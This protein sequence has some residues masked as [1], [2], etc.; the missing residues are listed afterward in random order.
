[1]FTALGFITSTAEGRFTC[2]FL[3][4]DL[5]Q[6]FSGSFTARVQ[7]FT[8]N[9][10]SINYTSPDQLKS[11]QSFHGFVGPNNIELSLVDGAVIDGVLDETLSPRHT[12]SGSG[13]WSAN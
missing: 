10:T 6:T 12:V 13:V 11:T 3:I 1:M 4:D 8:S 5:M 2:T 7:E 9:T